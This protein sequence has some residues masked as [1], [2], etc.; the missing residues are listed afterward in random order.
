MALMSESSEGVTNTHPALD[1]L[2]V[3]DIYESSGVHAV[4]DEGCNSTVRGTEW[5]TNAAQK[6]S[7]LGYSTRFSPNASMTFF[8]GL[9][10]V[11]ETL[12]VRHIP[13][14]ILGSDGE[15][16][17]PGILES[18]EIKGTAPLLLYA[19]AQLG[20]SKDLRTNLYGVR[21]P[22]NDQLIPIQMYVT[23]DSGLSCINLTDGLVLHRQ[24]GL[25]SIRSFKIPS[26]PFISAQPLW[27]MLTNTS[28]RFNSQLMPHAQPPRLVLCVL[29]PDTSF[30][31]GFRHVAACGSKTGVACASAVFGSNLRPPITTTCGHVVFKRI[32]HT[33]LRKCPGRLSNMRG[34]VLSMI[35]HPFPRFWEV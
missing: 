1:P 5:V 4:L 28:R 27:R 34:P 33:R 21:M 24:P 6:L 32:E 14:S 30:I 13:F 3:V 23:K 29:S 31:G 2:P 26:S 9:S 16:G 12:G 8:K 35:S 15:S 20:T 19:Q 10:G 11:T 17:V 7:N 22:S 25:I 18:H